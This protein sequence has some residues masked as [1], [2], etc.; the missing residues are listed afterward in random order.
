L[1]LG[2]T[3]K[4]LELPE[5]SAAAFHANG[6][7]SNYQ[8]SLADIGGDYLARGEYLKAIS[9]YRRALELARQLEDRLS[10]PKWLRNLANAYVHL[11]DPVLTKALKRKLN[12]LAEHWPKSVNARQRSPP[13]S[14]ESSHTDDHRAPVFVRA[15]QSAAIGGRW[16]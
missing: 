13:H 4:A 7:V 12:C 15:S 16:K 3:A 9:Y 2:E 5:G 1:H 8:V 11:G 10:V 14:G 6:S